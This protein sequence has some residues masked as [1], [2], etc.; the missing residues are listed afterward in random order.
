MVRRP[1]RFFV[2]YAEKDARLVTGLLD[3]LQLNFKASKAHDYAV[4][5]FHRLLVGE[6]W[7]ERIQEQIR[8][9][10]FGLLLLSPAFLASGYI[11]EY[12]LPPLLA[13]GQIVPVGL[14]P[15]DFKL[16]ASLSLDEYQVFRLRTT[17]GQWWYSDLR[18]ASHR[19]AFALD[20]FRQIEAHLSAA[21]S[22]TGESAS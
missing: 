9:C 15:V 22:A 6:R 19:E 3:L 17:N 7:H 14:K 1:V 11:K 18:V 13:G 2:S 4:W 8:N 16:H 20:L 12:E 10:D 21:P 5:E